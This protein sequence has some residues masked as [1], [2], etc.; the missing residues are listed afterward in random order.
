[1]T[2]ASDELRLRRQIFRKIKNQVKLYLGAESEALRGYA[3]AYRRVI[4]RDHWKVVDTGQ[5]HQAVVQSDVVFGGDFHAYAQAQ[6]AHLRILREVAQKRPII[7]GLECVLSKYQ[8]YVDAFLRDEITKEDFLDRIHWVESWGFSWS[9]YE[10]LFQLVKECGG[11]IVA[12]NQQ[13]NEVNAESFSQRDQHAA[14]ILNRI[15]NNRDRDELIYVI[16]GDLHIAKDHLPAQLEELSGP[17]KSVSLYLNPEK[18][19]FEV[20]KKHK[21]LTK[22]VIL[23]FSETEYCLLDSPPWVKWQ[24]YLLYLEEN[25]DEALDEDE[26]GLDFTEHIKS[27]LQLVCKDLSVSVTFDDHVYS[28]SDPDFIE[29]MSMRL[30]GKD[31]ELLSVYVLNDVSF[32]FSQL[33]VAYLSRATVNYAAD[34]VGHIFHS[35]LSESDFRNVPA[36]ASGFVAM[37]WIETISFFI[38]KLINPHRK[39]MNLADIKKLLTAFSEQEEQRPIQLA[40]DQKM[41]ELSVVYG[42]EPVF[43]DREEAFTAMTYIKAAKILGDY[44]GDR[45]YKNYRTGRLSRSDLLAWMTAPVQLE[46]ISKF[47]Y[48]VLKEL[49][50]MELAEGGI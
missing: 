43:V 44:H 19:Y 8:E 4:E 37:I 3:E 47:Y 25:I 39:A 12:L 23:K 6:R 45:L 5:L 1:M 46:E 35:Q 41:Y 2:V 32:Y 7:L 48:Q 16:Y 24:S 14:S 18:V 15:Y 34:L 13:V 42:E 40:L 11:S 27:L 10:P 21:D 20:V 22:G 29:L 9:Q 33:G 38:S 17:L 49:D 31:A 50:T 26:Q 36:D 30:E 28:F